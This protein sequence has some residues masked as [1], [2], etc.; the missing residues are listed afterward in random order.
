MGATNALSSL[1]RSAKNEFVYF[2]VRVDHFW[3]RGD[4]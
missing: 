3:F 1:N 2:V 4:K